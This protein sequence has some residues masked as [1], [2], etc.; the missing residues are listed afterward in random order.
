MQLQDHHIDEFITLY[1]EHFGVILERPVALE[2]AH[3]LCRLVEMGNYVVTEN[4]YGDTA[5]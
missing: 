4:E 5:R 2:K 1:A 3:M